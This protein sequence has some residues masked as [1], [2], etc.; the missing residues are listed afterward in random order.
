MLSVPARGELMLALPA[1]TDPPVGKVCA[2]AAPPRLLS[3]AQ[4][5]APS[6]NRIFIRKLARAAEL[7]ER[8]CSAD[9]IGAK[10]I[11][12]LFRNA[13]IKMLLRNSLFRQAWNFS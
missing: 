5:I 4:A 10:A 8:S 11:M 1:A 9:T 12:M 2:S 3:P 7:L 6:P 13:M